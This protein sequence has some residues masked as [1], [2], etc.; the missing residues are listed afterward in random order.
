MMDQ[1]V[2]VEPMC[3][4]FHTPV[5]PL[6]GVL[7]SVHLTCAG[8]IPQ[9]L[10]WLWDEARHFVLPSRAASTQQRKCQSTLN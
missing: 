10:L 7:C 8:A 4:S 1:H 2:Q 9:H 5:M 3:I 6:V